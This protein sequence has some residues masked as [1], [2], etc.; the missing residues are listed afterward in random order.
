VFLNVASTIKEL[1]QNLI[2]VTSK[3]FD[4]NILYCFEIII[5]YMIKEND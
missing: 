4:E 1:V 2:G 5:S 3:Y